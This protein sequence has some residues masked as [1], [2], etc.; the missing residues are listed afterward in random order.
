M[1][2]SD[3]P[4]YVSEL[5]CYGRLREGID[6]GAKSVSIGKEVHGL[7]IGLEHRWIDVLYLFTILSLWLEGH[8]VA[9]VI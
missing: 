2:L 1:N 9:L 5:L 7:K 3:L 4:T 8:R 6:R